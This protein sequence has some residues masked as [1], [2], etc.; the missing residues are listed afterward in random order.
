M[1]YFE[2]PTAS[3]QLGLPFL[4]LSWMHALDGICIETC[5]PVGEC[6][7]ESKS[8]E[9]KIY[10]EKNER[11]AAVQSTEEKTWEKREGKMRHN[12]SSCKGKASGIFPY[13]WWAESMLALNCFKKNKSIKV[14]VPTGR[15]HEVQVEI[16]WRGYG[17]SSSLGPGMPCSC[18]S[19]SKCQLQ[20]DLGPQFWNDFL[21]LGAKL[22]VI[23]N[24]LLFLF[25]F[26]IW[27]MFF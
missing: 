4:W 10:W 6:P 5:G 18:C 13:P 8:L 27:I 12:D 9:N 19:L 24:T 1:Q 7:E 15:K 16:C 3:F 23:K 26:A 2:A 22:F 14:L 11:I 25:F 21:I 17:A 20:L